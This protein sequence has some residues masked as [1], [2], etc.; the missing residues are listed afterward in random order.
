MSGGVGGRTALLVVDVQ[1]NQVEDWPVLHAQAM[2]AGI[3]A[4]V[5]RARAAGTPVIFVQNDGGEGEPDV[6]GTPGW[7]LHPALGRRP[8]EAVVR[9]TT[10]DS[11]H[12]TGL[13]ALLAADG[14]DALVV[15][16]FQ[17]DW[18]IDATVRR[19]AADGYATTLVAD[20]HSTMDQGRED[21]A[22]TI[23]RHNRELASIVTL[24]TAAEVAFG[25]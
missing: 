25:A 12:E 21:P 6:P 1:V 17:T 8:D 11:F 7:A 20:L 4:L 9:K 16:G 23:E 2:L 15:C 22:L 3:V 19:A 13:A 10:T 24:R 14:I 5:E 18:C